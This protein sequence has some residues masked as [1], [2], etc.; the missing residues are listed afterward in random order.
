MGA[1]AEADR[2]EHSGGGLGGR[3]DS[4]FHFKKGFSGHLADFA[5]FGAIVDE[6]RYHKLVETWQVQSGQTAAESFFPA[7]R[8]GL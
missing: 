4:L 1:D 3:E 7:Y 2:L 6:V 5:T 8:K